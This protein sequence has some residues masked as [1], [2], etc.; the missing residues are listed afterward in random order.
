MKSATETLQD[1]CNESHLMG[2]Q[3]QFRPLN[4]SDIHFKTSLAQ[5]ICAQWKAED[6]QSAIPIVDMAPTAANLIVPFQGRDESVR[7][8]IVQQ[9]KLL[10]LE[11]TNSSPHS[12]RFLAVVPTAELEEKKKAID[13]ALEYVYDKCIPMS[14][15]LRHCGRPIAKRQGKTRERPP[16]IARRQPQSQ[17]QQTSGRSD[18]AKSNSWGCLYAS[19]Q[20][21]TGTSLEHSRAA[22]AEIRDNEPGWD[23]EESCSAEA[24][25]VLQASLKDDIADLSNELRLAQQRNDQQFSLVRSDMDNWYSKGLQRLKYQDANIALVCAQ[26]DTRINNVICPLLSRTAVTP[27]VPGQNISTAPEQTLGSG[28]NMTLKAQEHLL[29]ELDYKVHTHNSSLVVLHGQIEDIQKTLDTLSSECETRKVAS[30]QKHPV[31]EDQSLVERLMHRS[32]QEVSRNNRL[33]RRLDALEKGRKPNKEVSGDKPPLN[34]SESPSDLGSE[35]CVMQRLE[36]LVQLDQMQPSLAALEEIQSQLRCLEKRIGT[37][38]DLENG[39]GLCPEKFVQVDHFKQ[40]FANLQESLLLDVCAEQSSHQVELEDY[41]Q[42]TTKALANL[43]DDIQRM[44]RERKMKEPPVDSTPCKNKDHHSYSDDGPSS[45]SGTVTPSC[46]QDSDKHLQAL[47]DQLDTWETRLNSVAQQVQTL[48]GKRLDAPDIAECSRPTSQAFGATAADIPHSDNLHQMQE[49]MEEIQQHLE[50][51]LE[52]RERVYALE[53]SIDQRPDVLSWS[54]AAIDLGVSQIT[55]TIPHNLQS[56][57]TDTPPTGVVSLPDLLS[58]LIRRTM[59]NEKET[60]AIPALTSQ[61]GAIKHE[62]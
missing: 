27:S 8:I 10:S 54:G 43:S 40:L 24:E 37:L 32:D 13:R 45:R 28:G 3:V 55:W 52:L 15:H 34:A 35:Q 5:I 60:Q 2:P 6:E 23:P 57:M 51:S 14:G 39:P 1:I 18:A 59:S 58:E 33:E 9:A 38:E 16:N 48:E 22:T 12:G 47:H 49:K 31:D 29:H 61:M 44:H 20:R 19:S 30:S 62:V 53:K 21:N 42:Q 50:K 36:Q 41:C 56:Y 25:T 26:I 7:N 17:S 46:S 4:N 11:T